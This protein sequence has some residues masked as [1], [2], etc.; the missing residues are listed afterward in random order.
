MNPGTNLVQTAFI[1]KET[2]WSSENL[3]NEHWKAIHEKR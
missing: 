3:G 1:E 2:E